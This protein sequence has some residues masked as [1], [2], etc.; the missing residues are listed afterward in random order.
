MMAHYQRKL[1]WISLLALLCIG[2]SACS[3]GGQAVITTTQST[4]PQSS[5]PPVTTTQ[6]Q[7]TSKAQTSVSTVEATTTAGIESLPVLMYHQFYDPARGETP[8]KGLESNWMTVAMFESH[9]KYLSDGEFYFPTWEEVYAYV[10]GEKTLPKKSLVITI[11]DGHSSFY[12]YAVPILERYQ[13]P[14]T[15]FI[16]T[17]AIKPETVERYSTQLISLQAHSDGMHTSGGNGRGL[18]TNLPHDKIVEDLTLCRKKLGGER[19]RVFDYPYGHYSEE[20]VSGV[21][22]AGFWLAFT[23]HYGRVK[24]GMD[25]LLLPRVR[26][27]SDITLTGFQHVV[28]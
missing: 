5:A 27:S 23:T 18:I 7:I 21:K 2:L 3:T 25:P 16:I 12:E 4:Q 24:P 13:I 20:A 28:Q 22:D 10:K 11:D 8:K 1:R 19:V 15:G 6:P 26:I 9:I 14:A 17:K